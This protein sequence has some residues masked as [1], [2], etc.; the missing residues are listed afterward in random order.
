MVL[1]VAGDLG[2]AVED[3][4]GVLRG[5]AGAADLVGSTLDPVEEA[6]DDGQVAEPFG[7]ELDGQVGDGGA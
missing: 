4:D 3:G 6:D 2:A 5:A 1:G 7:H